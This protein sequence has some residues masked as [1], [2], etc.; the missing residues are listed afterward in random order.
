MSDPNPQ[1]ELEQQ[2]IDLRIEHPE[3][4]E[5]QVQELADSIN[6]DELYERSY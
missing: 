5:V 3:M 4:D 1:A 6:N 2:L